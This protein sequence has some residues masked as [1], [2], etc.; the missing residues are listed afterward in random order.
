MLRNM[1]QMSAMMRGAGLGG[2]GALGTA[3][4][5]FPAPGLPS[6]MPG[7]ATANPT[8]PSA[9][10]Q[11][12]AAGA[13]ANTGATGVGLPNPALLQAFLGGGGLGGGPGGGLGGGFGGLG[14]LSSFGMPAATPTD[15]RPPEERFQ[16]QLQ[17]G[18]LFGRVATAVLTF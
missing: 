17:V 15:T 4:G 11:P 12:G 5:T 2:A 8:S 3:P 9:A 1:M 16:V 10:T 18:A 13:G 6:T 14:G 7:A